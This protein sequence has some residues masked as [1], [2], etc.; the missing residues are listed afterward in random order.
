VER[1]SGKLTGSDPAHRPAAF[2]DEPASNPLGVM[3]VQLTLAAT[4]DG[5]PVVLKAQQPE[6]GCAQSVQRL[7]E[8][9]VIDPG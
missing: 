3:W 7:A 5:L 2:A 4:E 8:M 1:L 6:P 9:P